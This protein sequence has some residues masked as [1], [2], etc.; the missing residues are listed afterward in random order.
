MK[1]QFIIRV[2]TRFEATHGLRS[3]KGK[4]EPIHKH[5]W[6]IEAAFRCAEL[7][8]EGIGI[9]FVEAQNTLRNLAQNFEQKSINNV[10]P[11]DKI[12]PTSEHLARWLYDQLE[13]RFSGRDASIY[14]VTVWE[15]P[16]ASVSYSRPKN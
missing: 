14:E 9:D 5:S 4:P 3:Y 15:G 7:D 16:H 11:F 10:P 8:N 12:N 6:K 1:E 13:G 2:E